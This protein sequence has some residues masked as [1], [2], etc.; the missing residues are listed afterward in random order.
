MTRSLMCAIALLVGC[1]PA[2][3]A[4]QDAGIVDDVDAKVRLDGGIDKSAPC[5]GNFGQDLT[6]GF[7]RLDATVIAVVPPGS[8]TCP[9]P[10]STHLILEV[11]QGG[12]AYRM[13]AAVESSSGNPVMAFAERDAVLAGPPW[14]EG[15]HVGVTFDYVNTLG[16][17]RLDFAPKPMEELADVITDQ[18]EL[19][20]RVSIFATVEDQPDSAHL[21]HRNFTGA[22]GAIVIR[23][24]T[25][26]HYLLLRF[27]NQLF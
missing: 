25:A 24:D 11:R 15:W 1:R 2:E 9:R 26:P 16:V 18:L 8:T 17:H 10:N 13:V 23:A 6:N 22:D 7:G 5:V 20:A 21:I 12:E 19:G 27:D 14:A 3:P 4:S